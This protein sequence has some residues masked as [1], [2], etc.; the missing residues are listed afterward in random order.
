MEVEF[1]EEL[2]EKLSTEKTGLYTAA[3]YVPSQQLLKNYMNRSYG[4]DY[5]FDQSEK[6]EGIF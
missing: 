3:T 2:K 5:D 6:I 4:N 1:A